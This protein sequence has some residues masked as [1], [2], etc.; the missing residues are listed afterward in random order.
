VQAFASL[1]T[2]ILIGASRKTFIR[3]ILKTAD[4]EDI[5]PDLPVV[6]TGSQA[7]VAAAVLNGAHMVR[8]HDVANTVA[9]IKIVDSVL[10]ARSET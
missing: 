2:P 10:N 1:D 5:Q 7:A 8:V 9:T 3:K 4:V 6:E